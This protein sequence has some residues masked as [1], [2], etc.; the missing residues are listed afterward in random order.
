[1]C[2]DPSSRRCGTT[3]VA[4]KAH[5]PLEISVHV[6]QGFILAVV[7]WLNGECILSPSLRSNTFLVRFE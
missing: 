7:E 5:A 4:K 3:R 2:P 6:G 1:M